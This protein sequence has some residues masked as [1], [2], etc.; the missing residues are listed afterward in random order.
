MEQFVQEQV[1]HLVRKVLKY[2]GDDERKDCESQFGVDPIDID[3]VEYERVLNESNHIYKYIY[4]LDRLIRQ[5]EDNE[6]I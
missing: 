1:I 6:R 5:I 2:I 4:A 3:R